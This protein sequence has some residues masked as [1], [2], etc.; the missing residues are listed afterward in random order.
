MRRQCAKGGCQRIASAG[1]RYC[2]PHQTEAD[3]REQFRKELLQKELARDPDSNRRQSVYKT[4]RW[5]RLRTRHL[6]DHPLCEHPGCRAIGEEVDHRTPH[7][8]DPDLIWDPENLQTLCKRHHSSKTGREI[9]E[10]RRRQREQRE[11]EQQ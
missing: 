2:A 4:A 5:A 11:R 1:L 10:R 8:G 9:A 3:Q 6:A 7:R